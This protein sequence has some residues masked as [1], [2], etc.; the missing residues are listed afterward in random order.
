MVKALNLIAQA[1]LYLTFGAV[2]GYFSSAPAYTHVDPDMA[3]MKLSFTHAGQPVTECRRFT[4]EELEKL[5]PNMRRPF[6][7]PR[8]RVPLL[9][10]VDM[11]GKLLYRAYLPPTGLAHDGASTVYQRFVVPPGR[12]HL[13]ARLRDSK[14]TQG[15]DY[16]RAADVTLAPQQS[17][18]IDF[19]AESGGFTF[20]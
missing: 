13:V 3:V 2:V 7:C 5:A 18:V 14:R 17:F 6:D 19:R 10:E 15:F 1:G 20:G 16:E 8:A 11:D 4:Q 12:H 9:I